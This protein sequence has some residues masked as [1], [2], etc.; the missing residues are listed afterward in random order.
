MEHK[1]SHINEECNC[2]EPVEAGKLVD[3]AKTTFTESSGSH[4]RQE[5]EPVPAWKYIET[6]CAAQVSVGRYT[7]DAHWGGMGDTEEIRSLMHLIAA[8]PDLYAA[9]ESILKEAA[10]VGDAKEP[11]TTWIAEKARAALALVDDRQKEAGDA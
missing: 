6:K 7:I 10:Y 8:A 5:V 9:L 1:R 3:E 2:A 4:K 11:F